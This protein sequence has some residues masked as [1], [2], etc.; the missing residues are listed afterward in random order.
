MERVILLKT[1]LVEAS[2]FGDMPDFAHQRLAVILL[3]NFMEIQ[4]SEHMKMKFSWEDMMYTG[5][6]SYSLSARKKILYNY[7]DLLNACVKEDIILRQELDQLSFCHDVR[8]NLYHKGQEEIILTSVALNL[9]RAI[10]I[11][12]QPSWCSARNFTS[13]NGGAKYPYYSKEAGRFVHD[14][15]SKEEW[16]K[17]LRTHFDFDPKP[18]E[19]PSKLLAGHL[20]GKIEKSKEYYQFLL[21][22][23]SIFSPES[24]DWKLNEFLL[25]Y[26]FFVKNKFEIQLLKEEKSGEDY[27]LAFR[28]CIKKYRASWKSVKED[29][30]DWLLNKVNLISHQNSALALARFKAYRNEVYL[31]Y[32]ALAK[33]V[34]DLEQQIDMAIDRSRE[35]RN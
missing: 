21:E 7:S 2:K 19:T 20:L 23:Y 3:D 6:K 15:N 10:I 17:F 26:S 31:V 24:N 4:L 27:N 32:D 11:K 28:E 9:L 33:A 29:R 12:Y 30:L 1:Q 18:I 14:Y 35:R 8:N 13:S 16:E 5:S 22:E 34:G 25:Y